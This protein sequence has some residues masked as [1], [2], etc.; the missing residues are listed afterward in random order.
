MVDRGRLDAHVEAR[1]FATR[2]RNDGVG[3]NRRVVVREVERRRPVL[4]HAGHVE[5]VR[6]GDEICRTWRRVVDREVV[7]RLL[8]GLDDVIVGLSDVQFDIDL[9]GQDVRITDGEAVVVGFIA[10]FVRVRPRDVR[11]ASQVVGKGGR[12]TDGGLAAVLWSELVRVPAGHRRNLPW[13]DGRQAVAGEVGAVEAGVDH[14]F[15]GGQVARVNPRDVDVVLVV[16]QEGRE[17]RVAAVWA[18]LGQA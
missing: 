18:V 17:D 10:A 3:E 7:H 5:R 15:A 16:G 6:V 4:R 14:F 8:A 9:A 12:H 11:A 13:V 1:Q 2:K